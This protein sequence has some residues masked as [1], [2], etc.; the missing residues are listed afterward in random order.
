M[1]GKFVGAGQG[2]VGIEGA[3]EDGGVDAGHVHAD[4][5]AGTEVEVAY[6]GVAHLTVGET[7]EV[8]AGLQECVGVFAEKLVVDGLAGLGYG[9][10]VG[11]GAIAPAVQDGENDGFGHALS[12]YKIRLPLEWWGVRRFRVIPCL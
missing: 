5:A 3:V 10:A 4:D 12:G 7:D 11:L 1:C 2:G 8:I 9:V 6:L